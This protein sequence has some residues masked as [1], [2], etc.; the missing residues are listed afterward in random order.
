MNNRDYVFSYLTARGISNANARDVARLTTNIRAVD[1]YL[2]GR[3][4]RYSH[5]NALRVVRNT[6]NQNWRALN[7]F[8]NSFPARFK[9]F[10]VASYILYRFEGMS[11]RDALNY[12][13]VFMDNVMIHMMLNQ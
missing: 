13:R 11:H 7:T 9:T 6:T 4:Y 1:I 3:R 10:V 8:S 12:M 5:A 2:Q